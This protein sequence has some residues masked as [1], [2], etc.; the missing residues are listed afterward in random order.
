MHR[1]KYCALNIHNYIDGA[2]ARFGSCFFTVK[3][4]VI[5]ACTFAF[6]DS[7]TNPEVMGTAQHFYSIMRALFTELKEKNRLLNKE[8][9]N[10]ANA[11]EYISTMKKG[12]LYRLGRNLDFCIE[13]HIHGDLSLKDD[14]ES[15]YIDSSFIGTDIEKMAE[16]LA[17]QYAIVLHYIPKRQFPVDLID[18]DWKGPLARPVAEKI[19]TKFGNERK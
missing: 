16:L 12:V 13:T 4:H 14:I 15:F 17:E 7:S 18:D 19:L 11:V 5:N 10:F 3:P 6:G 2:S 9:M 1:P 8:N